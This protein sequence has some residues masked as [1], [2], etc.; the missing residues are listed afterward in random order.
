MFRI[1]PVNKLMLDTNVLIYGMDAQSIY[2]T[3]ATALL[4]DPAYELFI[5]TKVVSEFFAVC[6]KLKVATTDALNFYH[7][8][9][10]NIE[11]LYP[12]ALSLS[13]FESLIQSIHSAAIFKIGG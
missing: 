4:T 9:Q 10:K 11:I 1:L 8:L 12:N 5:S 3:S 13:H 6:S 2:H 7:E